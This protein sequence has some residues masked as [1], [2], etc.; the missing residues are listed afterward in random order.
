MVKI[1]YLA[2]TIDVDNFKINHWHFIKCLG[3]E[4]G[5]VAK[6]DN[7]KVVKDKY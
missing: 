1:H 5:G 2:S 6:C 7:R 3:Q 4:N